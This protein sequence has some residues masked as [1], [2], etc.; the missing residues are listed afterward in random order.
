MQRL[1]ALHGGW[2]LC[3]AGPRGRGLW[4]RGLAL[5]G[6]GGAQSHIVDGIQEVLSG[7]AVT[8]RTVGRIF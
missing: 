2:G 3:N 7:V 5:A 8:G 1:G 4:G 6:V